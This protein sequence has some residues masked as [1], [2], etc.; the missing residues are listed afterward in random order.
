M[1]RIL[2]GAIALT[3]NAAALHAQDYPARHAAALAYLDAHAD[4]ELK[5]MIPMR[6]GTRL[7]TEILFPKGQPLNLF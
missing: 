6:D 4:R 2:L 1:K 7:S 5:V 3:G